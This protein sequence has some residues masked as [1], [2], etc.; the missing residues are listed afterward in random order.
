M[1]AV[2]N[3]PFMLDAGA[4]VEL[5]AHSSTKIVVV[6]GSSASAASC[7]SGTVALTSR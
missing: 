1:T 3:V 5:A 7:A 6:G 4:P 2:M